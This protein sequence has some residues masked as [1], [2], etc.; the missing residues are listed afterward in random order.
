MSL[1]FPVLLAVGVGLVLG[2]RL[3]A[4]AELRLRAP[5]LFLAAIAL[6]LVAFPTVFL[7]WS[8][9]EKL[10]S[11][12]WVVSYGLLVVGAVLNREIA[13][14]PVVALGMSLN[15][16]VILANRGTMPVTHEAMR[17]AGRID[18]VHANSTAMTEPNLP[19][20]VDRWAAPDWIPLANVFSVGDVV[21]AVGAFV[22][23]LS[24]MDVRVPWPTAQDRGRDEAAI[25]NNPEAGR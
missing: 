15:L 10:A 7:P 2:G 17:D 1:L 21:I 22:L 18:P 5:W 6:Q 13:G 11:V 23:V 12:L 3:G 4:L 20:L 25:S 24:A 19:W 14:V 9:D 8:T 16:V